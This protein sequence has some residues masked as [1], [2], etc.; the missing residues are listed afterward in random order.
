MSDLCPITKCQW[1]GEWV[2]CHADDFER[3]EDGA[4]YRLWSCPNC[5]KALN[6]TIDEDGTFVDIPFE[7]EWV[8]HEEAETRTGWKWVPQKEA[9]EFEGEESEPT[10]E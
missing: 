8:P 7:P 2:P 5:D 4:Q 3:P 9:A 1:C 6:A 10:D